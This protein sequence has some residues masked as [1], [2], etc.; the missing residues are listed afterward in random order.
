[1]K[2]LVISA[3]EEVRRQLSV[4]VRAVERSTGEPWEYLESANGLEG[5]RRA[6]RDRPEVV[7]VDEIVTGA[8]GFAVTKDLKG[9]TEPFSG[10]VIIVLA[11]SQDEWLAE[12]SGADAWFVHPVDPFAIGDKLTELVGQTQEVG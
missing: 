3:D 6:W 11:R 4:A 2:A 5:I 7:V 9:A 12:W 8:G 10:A 1:M